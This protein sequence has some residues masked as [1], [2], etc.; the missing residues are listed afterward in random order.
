VDSQFILKVEAIRMSETS[1]IELICKLCVTSKPFRQR[2]PTHAHLAVTLSVDQW[3]GVSAGPLSCYAL[4]KQK[5]MP[6][7][8]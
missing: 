2:E 7:L 3:A 5:C 4:K 6:L 1:A 8:L